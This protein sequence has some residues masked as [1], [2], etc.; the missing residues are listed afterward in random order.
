MGTKRKQ[1][2]TADDL[3]ARAEEHTR[4]VTAR[5]KPDKDDDD[6]ER[7]EPT[8]PP[9]S[10]RIVLD[11]DEDD[12][13][14]E[15]EERAPRSERRA[16]RSRERGRI[17]RENEVLR[18]RLDAIER[19]PQQPVVVHAP[20]QTQTKAPEDEAYEREMRS[21]IAESD[22]L[23]SQS[24]QLS[25][26]KDAAGNVIG[27]TPEE[28][29]SMREKW[30]KLE[31]RRIEAMT[32]RAMQ[33]QG[34]GQRGSSPTEVNAAILQGEYGDVF[35][36]ENGQPSRALRWGHA[37]HQ[38]LLAEGAPN[39]LATA[40]KALDESRARFNTAPAPRRAAPSSERKARFESI[41]RGGGSSDGG[42]E[43]P[44]SVTLTQKQMSM[45]EERYPNMKPEKAHRLYA[46]KVVL[47]K[48][49]R[50]RA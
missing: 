48:R 1:P 26:R 25:A 2:M 18:A 28:I 34:G 40:R 4:R 7:D 9:E 41:S 5:A 33:R 43:R 3:E 15:G 29:S 20:P 27:A 39:T 35:A 46:E 44:R 42:E 12:E 22:Q 31:E 13:D 21:I 16:E 23:E 8:V 36:L 49:D 47:K 30:V 19:R 6:D 50:E 37:R 17:M 14:D 45:A 24:R 38:Q 11:D 32:G 10:K